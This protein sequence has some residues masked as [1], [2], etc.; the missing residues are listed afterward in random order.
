MTSSRRLPNLTLHVFEQDGGWN[1]G[2]TID[3]VHGT[4]RKVIA[5][6]E[7]V[8]PS[9]ADARADGERAYRRELDGASL[10]DTDVITAPMGSAAC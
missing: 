2:L 9:A 7:E 5:Y 8:F 3:R 1:W 4:G 6:S 10:A